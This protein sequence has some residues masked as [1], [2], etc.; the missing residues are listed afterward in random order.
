VEAISYSAVVKSYLT[1]MRGFSWQANEI[2]MIRSGY[3]SNN[4]FQESNKIKRTKSKIMGYLPR[5]L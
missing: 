3:Y 4:N 2:K 1:Q 5:V